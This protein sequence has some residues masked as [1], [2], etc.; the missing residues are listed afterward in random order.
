[1]FKGW[2][3]DEDIDAIELI[4]KS[5]T[6]P[7]KTQIKASVKIAELTDIGQRIRMKL[8]FA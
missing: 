3:S 1:M 4:Y 7:E 5:S 6:G 8:L 2:V